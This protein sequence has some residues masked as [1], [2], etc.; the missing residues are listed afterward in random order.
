MAFSA[1]WGGELLGGITTRIGFTA[2]SWDENNFRPKEA[3]GFDIVSGLSPGSAALPFKATCASFA[4]R[5][6]MNSGPALG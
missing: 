6:I 1:A 4:R 3:M 2:F 5:Y